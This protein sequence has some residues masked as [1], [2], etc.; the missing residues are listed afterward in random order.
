[1][2]VPASGGKD[3]VRHVLRGNPPASD[4]VDHFV[5]YGF[6]AAWLLGMVGIVVGA[7]T[8]NPRPLAL[9][10]PAGLLVAI[11]GILTA[12]N[13]RGV[14]DRMREREERSLSYRLTRTQSTTTFGGVMLAFIGVGWMALGTI[15]LL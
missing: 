7:G 14:R 1:M 11:I 2:E 10:A 6:F 4:P 8:R 3:W 13:L 9:I 15:F 5:R 12:T